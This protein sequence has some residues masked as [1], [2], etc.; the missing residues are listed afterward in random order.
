MGGFFSSNKQNMFENFRLYNIYWYDS[1]SNRADWEE[2]FSNV[3]FNMTSNIKKIITFFNNYNQKK[4]WI[5]IISLSKGE[6]LISELHNKKNI[7]AFCLYNMS[8]QSLGDWTQ[9][10]EKIKGIV[11]KPEDLY[12]ILLKIN[13]EYIPDLNLESGK[14]P[15]FNYFTTKKYIIRNFDLNPDKIN[16]NKYNQYVRNHLNIEINLLNQIYNKNEKNI[17]NFYLSTLSFYEKNLQNLDNNLKKEIELI[18]PVI[19]NQKDI[20]SDTVI[21][22]LNFLYILL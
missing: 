1:N 16:N 19:Y 11:E 2:V 21:E 13:S 5:V 22:F 10:Y 9:K 20:K 3:I 17:N 7:K 15:N 18:L 14:V 6:K 4:P 8:P 12:K